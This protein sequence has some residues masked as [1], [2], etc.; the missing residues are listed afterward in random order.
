M[1]DEMVQDQLDQ[2][3]DMLKGDD[4]PSVK[5]PE[6]LPEPEPIPEPE[7]DPT[8][9]PEPEPEPTPEPEPI[10]GPEPSPEPE[11]EIDIEQIK[12]DNEELRKRI[13]EMSVP[14]PEPK[15]EPKPVEPEPIKLD[16][17][18]FIGDAD[19][20]EVTRDPVAFNKLL[21]KVFVQGVDTA[22]NTI[23]EGVLRSIP[24]TVKNTM[25]TVIAL[26]K[27][28]DDFYEDNKDL[29]P[30]KK[31]VSAVFEEAFAENPDKGYLEVMKGV[32]PEVRK[33]LELHKK[34]VNPE[35]DPPDSNN[36]PKLPRKKSQPR[37]PSDKP[38]TDPLLAEIDEMNKSL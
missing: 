15:P 13:D 20:D 1:A 23:S 3:A 24:D 11:P 21:N 8:P 12:K 14:K 29:V 6:D 28:S 33:R 19:M 37:Q 18:D 36:P 38:D 22:R 17:I 25:N 5:V 7:P 31:V 4:E 9:D 26:K 27:A 10:P 30:F 32:G 16:E 2:M 34:A 35:P